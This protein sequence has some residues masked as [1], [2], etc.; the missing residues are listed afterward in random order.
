[1]FLYLETINVE[2]YN[3][4]PKYV[5]LEN[6]LYTI[7]FYNVENF[8]S[9]NTNP[10]ES[11]LPNSFTKWIDNRYQNKVDKI[12]FALGQI[13]KHSN[14]QLPLFIG[15]AEVE[16]TDVLNDL[17]HHENLI[18]GKYQYLLYESLDERKINV[19]CLYRKDLLTVIES[20][21]IRIIFKD[22]SGEKSY[23]RDIL[24]VKTKFK[25]HIV[26]FFVLHLPSKIDTEINQTKRKVILERLRNEIDELIDNDPEAFVVVMGDFNDTPTSDN[27]RLCLN[28]RAKVEELKTKELYNPMV[29]LMSYKRGS[30]IFRKQW[31]LF[32]QILFNKTFLTQKSK[33]KPIK[34]DIFDEP[35]LTTNINKMGA[36]PFRTFLGT[37]YVGGYSDHFPIYSIISTNF[38]ES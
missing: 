15:L 12:S 6:E 28:T 19:G 34:T 11:F 31:M 29:N 37:K 14:N 30:L 9:V 1:M 24:S 23:T 3:F 35:F 4:K 8:Y 13:K 20:K 27:I 38:V 17:I 18:E 22:Q 7:V 36:L 33:L 2:F 32:D 21:P 26:Y 25:D 10:E 16:N 5:V